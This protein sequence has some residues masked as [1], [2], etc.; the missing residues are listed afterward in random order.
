MVNMIRECHLSIAL[1]TLPPLLGSFFL[2]VG[3]V[4]AFRHDRALTMMP[5]ADDVP[6]GLATFIGYS[7]MVWVGLASSCQARPACVRSSS[8]CWHSVSRW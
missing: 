6:R 1:W 2:T 3:G 5:W 7:E 8:H 4:K